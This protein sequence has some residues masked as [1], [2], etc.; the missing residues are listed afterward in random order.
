M[1]PNTSTSS[2][3]GTHE[4]FRG[5]PIKVNPLEPFDGDRIKLSSFLGQVKLYIAMIRSGTMNETQ[6]VMLAGS[7]L[8][9]KAFE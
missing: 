4:E 2:A 3:L 1:T 8:R 9:D 5:A 6:L 7:Y